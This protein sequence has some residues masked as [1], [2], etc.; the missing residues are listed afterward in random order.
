[1]ENIKVLKK[2]EDNLDDSMNKEFSKGIERLLGDFE[3]NGYKIERK[4]QIL[5]N[6][7]LKRYI[8]GQE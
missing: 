1:M 5:H 6:L 3:V 7:I 4:L 2:Y 8:Q